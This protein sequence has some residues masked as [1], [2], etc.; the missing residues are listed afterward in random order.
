MHLNY[1]MKAATD[2]FSFSAWMNS[3]LGAWYTDMNIQWCC[4]YSSSHK[5]TEVCL[6]SM[7]NFQSRV[8]HS[9]WI[10]KWIR[11]YFLGEWRKKAMMDV[12]QCEPTTH[13]YDIITSSRGNVN[14]FYKYCTGC[15]LT[16]QGA[17][18][19]SLSVFWFLL[20][21]RTNTALG[22]LWQ[23]IAL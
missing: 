3:R 1:T 21:H 18:C 8:D 12:L 20:D 9:I 22:T 11:P 17:Q 19:K 16:E 2:I 15:T 13:N 4:Q 5:K 6:F 10:T 23:N 7:L 14:P